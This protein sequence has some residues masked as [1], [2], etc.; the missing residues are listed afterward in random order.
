VKV[1]ADKLTSTLTTLDLT[2]NH[3]TA[4]GRVIPKEFFFCPYFQI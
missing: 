1:L 2:N 4:E 3:I